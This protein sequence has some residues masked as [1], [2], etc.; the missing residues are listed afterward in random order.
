MLYSDTRPRNSMTI[1][2]YLLTNAISLYMYMNMHAFV[3]Y[4]CYLFANSCIVVFSIRF[5]QQLFTIN[6]LPWVTFYVDYTVLH[7]LNER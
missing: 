4:V 1:V 3:L 6:D 2:M 5:F 7:L